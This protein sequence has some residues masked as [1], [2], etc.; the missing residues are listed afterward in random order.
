MK[1][2]I[3]QWKIPTGENLGFPDIDRYGWYMPYLKT[4]LAL[5]IVNG[6]PDGTFKPAN[7]VLR[8]EALVTML[9]TGKAK[10][11]IIIPTNNYSQPYY[12]TP[13]APDTKWYLSY[14]WFAKANSLTDN[15]YY[16][17]PGTYMT[18]GEMES[19]K[20]LKMKLMKAEQDYLQ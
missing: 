13:N 11:G 5:G 14:A 9:N 12:D 10:Y 1:K 6:Y 2:G 8:I 4:A 15:D 20:A 17:Y 16:L 7:A 3:S 19:A 18:R